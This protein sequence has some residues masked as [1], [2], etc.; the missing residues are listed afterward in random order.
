MLALSACGDGGGVTEPTT[1]SAQLTIATTG[2][3]LDRDGYRLA[4]DGR[5]PVVVQ[6]NETLSVDD[7]TP[8]THTLTI[9]GVAD[10]CQATSSA[11]QTVQVAAGSSTPVQ[12]A[13]G[14]VANR[15]AYAHFENGVYTYYVRR[16]G[17]AGHTRIAMTVAVS[18]MDWS[19]DG[20][21]LVYHATGSSAPGRMWIVDV[22][23]GTAPRPLDPAGGEVGIHPSWSPDGARI[24]FAGA[25][26]NTRRGIYTMKPDG[27]DVRAL[28]P[29]EGSESMPA[30]SPDGTRIAYRRDVTGLTEVWVMNADGTGQQRVAGLNST[31]YT[32]IDWTADGTRIVFSTPDFFGGNREVYSVRP[33]GTDLLRLTDTPAVDERYV[34]VLADGRISYN[35][36][37]TAVPPRDDIWMMNADGTGAAS[38]TST[39]D[40]HETLPAWQ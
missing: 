26:A 24:A 33:D 29:D 37:N 31:T 17:D 10:N 38:F 12:F 20:Y 40:L 3:V 30:W 22:D 19:A 25:A 18:R 13:V 4:V 28:T 23:S 36:L 9:S 14:C 8:G 5:A 39:A 16:L 27:T 2:R 21:R 35:R 15:V 7:L 34:A 32:H 6:A 1:G 11:T